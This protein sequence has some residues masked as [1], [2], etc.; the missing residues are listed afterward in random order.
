M[1]MKL[2]P[3]LK[4]RATLSRRLGHCAICMHCIHCHNVPTSLA[5]IVS[6]AQTPPSVLST[7]IGRPNSTGNWY[8]IVNISLNLPCVHSYAWSHHWP[9]LWTVPGCLPH[10]CWNLILPVMT[11]PFSFHLY[12]YQLNYIIPVM[13]LGITWFVLWV[14]LIYFILKIPPVLGH[15]KWQWS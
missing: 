15:N 10:Q 13:S 8:F 2:G 3:A 6:P 12:Q 1:G 9:W 7:A 14:I 4:L 11:K 5:A